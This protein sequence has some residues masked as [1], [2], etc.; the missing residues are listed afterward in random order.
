MPAEEVGKF[1]HEVALARPGQPEELA[2][3]YVLL[4]SSDGSFMTG[5]LI[6]V[7][8]GKLSTDA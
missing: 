8:G 3:A 6:Q 2:P 1:G 5:S 7:T 4:A